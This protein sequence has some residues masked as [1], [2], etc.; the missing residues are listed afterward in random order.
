MDEAARAQFTDMVHSNAGDWKIIQSAFR[1]FAADLPDRVLQHMNLLSGDFGGFAVDRMTHSLQTATRSLRDGRDEEY[2]VCAL[3]HDIGDTL[4]T[5]N[6]PDVAAAILKPFVS[7]RNHWMILNHGAFQGHYY[8]HFVGMDRNVRQKFADHPNYAYTE[9][10]CAK[11][12]APAF[13]PDYDTL[14]LAHFEPMLR[15]ILSRP[16]NS[17]YR[18]AFEDKIGRASCRERV[19]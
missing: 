14:P 16:I 18:S 9:E 5:Y 12:D 7:E 13:D 3:L 1:V 15:N 17:P 4:G 8:F 11:Y 19:S 10:F 6:H 2:V